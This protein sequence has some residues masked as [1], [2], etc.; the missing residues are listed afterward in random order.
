MIE[1]L[2]YFL[3]GY[4]ILELYGDSK[5]R[6]I[7]L[8]KNK[9][10]EIM[11]LFQIAQVWYCKI[12][13]SDY[14]KLKGLLKKTKCGCKIKEKRGFPFVWRKIRE[15]RGII[16]GCLI[17]FLIISQCKERIWNISVEGGFLHTREQILQVMEEELEVY[18]GV[19]SDQVDCFEIEKR[20][21]LDYNEIG[22]ISVE[23]RGCRLYVMLNESVMPQETGKQNNPGHI[24]A[25]QDGIV[26]RLEVMAGIPQVK[27]GEEVKK[28][29]ILISGIVPVV[30]DYEALLRNE[31]VVARGTVF[32][33][34]EFSY[35]AR[36]SMLYEQK[37]YKNNRSGLEIFLFGR[38]L[39]SYIP[40]YSEGKY[41]IMGIDI[42]P[43]TFE[44]YEAPVRFRKY[45]IL[46]YDTELIQMTEKE[47]T[48]KAEADWQAFLSD[49]E[50]QGVELL[51]A[52]YTSQIS[53]KN[54][55]ITG[56]ITAC[57][58]FISYQDIS[59]E[60]WKI[61]DEYSRDDP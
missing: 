33:E 21:R 61:E 8:C 26:R 46:Q 2:W 15:R 32:L 41:D 18:G 56:T 51:R 60:E 19:R 52:S 54:Y 48:G 39:F 31:P 35:Q 23:K 3:Q 1:R 6:F 27:I 7:N 5:G 4:L 42:V 10:I 49:W 24:V 17:F 57:G 9:D 30:G 40:R 14:K 20:L 55:Y 12:K 44:D 59:E 25:A 50:S 53:Q 11:Q 38:K 34:S 43:Y 45:R 28:G 22:W 36:Y 16:L 37:K 58:N 13:C 47:I 29:D